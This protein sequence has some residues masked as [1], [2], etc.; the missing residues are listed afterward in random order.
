M[1]LGWPSLLERWLNA[2]GVSVTTGINVTMRTTNEA[3]KTP[4]TS[5]VLDAAE[6]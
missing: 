5:K 4:P 3:L 2:P 1:G 6:G